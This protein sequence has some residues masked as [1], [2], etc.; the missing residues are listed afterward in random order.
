M[1]AMAKHAPNTERHR[2][3]RVK[4]FALLGSLLAFCVLIYLVTLVRLG[5]A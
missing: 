2:K 3:Q 1:S 4:N 5:G